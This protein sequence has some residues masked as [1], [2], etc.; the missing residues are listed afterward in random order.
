MSNQVKVIHFNDQK[1]DSRTQISKPRNII[2]KIPPNNAGNT[3]KKN[4]AYP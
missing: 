1:I 3:P 2:N 4:P